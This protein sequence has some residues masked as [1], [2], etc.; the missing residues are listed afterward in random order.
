[1]QAMQ[2]TPVVP[3][4]QVQSV[5]DELEL[6]EFVFAGHMTQVL[7]VLAPT[8]TEY[9][10]T[11]H[12]A[13]VLAP[14]SNEYRPA[15]HSEQTSDPVTPLYFP[16]VHRVQTAPSGPVDPK[17]QVQAAM[18]ELELTE[19]EFTGQATQV[20]ETFD[21]TVD[22]YVPTLQSVQLA[23]PLM[24]LYLPG[25]HAEHSPLFAPVYPAMHTQADLEGI[26]YEFAG[27]PVHNAFEKSGL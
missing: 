1:M 22:E 19:I 21:P 16:G 12:S 8:T 25:T 18:D 24:F 4:L 7:D 27:Q 15:K 14:T 13:Q 20:E 10:P 23:L 11:P 26:A 5:M 2:G 17:A 9:V 6:V 3:G